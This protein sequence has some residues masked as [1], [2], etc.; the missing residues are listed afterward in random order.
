MSNYQWK[1][2]K[3]IIVENAHKDPFLKIEDLA[4]MA[5]TTS[6]YVRTIL[7]ES[8]I[9]LMKLR[10]D[11]ARKVENMNIAVKDKL[12]FYHLTRFP[13]QN[14]VK[15]ILTDKLYLNNSADL[16]ELGVNI[17]E[18]YNYYSFLHIIKDTPWSA[19][20]LFMKKGKI[21]D[22][23]ILHSF[24]DLV[25]SLCYEVKES[26]IKISDLMIDIE[27]ANGQI[28]DSINI[29]P[30]VPIYRVKQTLGSSDSVYAVMLAY[31]DTRQVS[32]NVS[33]NRGLILKKKEMAV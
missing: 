26:G 4:K 30:L 20:T 10:K 3:E 22:G 9:S 23:E 29:T 33:P 32:L 24:N 15:S 16:S 25:D 31:F 6:R 27:I 7:S 19:C 12:F 18:D 13:Y 1:T 28:A 8:D 14:K 5:K 21:I 11:Y 2:K 17:K